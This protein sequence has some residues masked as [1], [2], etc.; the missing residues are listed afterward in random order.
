MA[1]CGW[2]QNTGIKDGKVCSCVTRRKA[3]F[4]KGGKKKKD[5]TLT[6]GHK[7]SN[8]KFLHETRSAMWFECGK[9]GIAHKV[10]LID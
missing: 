5:D 8:D 6:S 7:H 4:A 10:S 2:C 1:I 3:F 9:C